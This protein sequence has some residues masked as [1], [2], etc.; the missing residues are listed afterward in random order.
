VDEYR[1]GTT[2]CQTDVGE[3]RC[4]ERGDVRHRI[5]LLDVHA[6]PCLVEPRRGQVLTR[7][8]PLVEGFGGVQ[9]GDDVGGQRLAGVDV[10]RVRGEHLRPEDPHL[11]HLTRE[12]HEVAED[13]GAGEVREGHRREQAVQRVPEL[14]EHRR[15]LVE[16]QE[17]RLAGGRLGH[18]EVVH[19]DRTRTAQVRLRHDGVHPCPAALGVAR[20]EVEEEQAERGSVGVVH[21]KTRTSGW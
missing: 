5:G 14:V 20:V 9:A 17:R 3:G 13:R 1:V 16:R 2:G 21:S 6:V 8:E 18:V 10:P 11:V 7:G 4:L 19:D 12:L 15:D